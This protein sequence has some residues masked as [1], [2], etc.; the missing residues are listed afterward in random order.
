MKNQGLLKSN[1]NS[2]LRDE[3]DYYEY[4]ALPNFNHNNIKHLLPYDMRIPRDFSN[5]N[6]YKSL[7][8]GAFLNTTLNKS[9]KGDQD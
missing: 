5:T 9:K 6:I 2:P 1:K 8:G 7:I 4:Y 3:H